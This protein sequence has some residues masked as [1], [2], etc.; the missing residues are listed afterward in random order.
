MRSPVF[1]ATTAAA[2]LLLIISGVVL[3]LHGGGAN[4][5]FA[6]VVKEFLK[7]EN[8]RYKITNSTDGKISVKLDC[9]S[10][11][12]RGREELRDKD[13]KLQNVMIT[14]LKAGKL[15]TLWMTPEKNVANLS[16]V[17]NFPEDEPMVNRVRSLLLKAKD[18]RANDLSSLGE[19]TIDGHRAVGYRLKTFFG[20]KENGCNIE[21][22]IWADAE[23]LLPIRIES[24]YKA[25]HEEQQKTPGEP[26]KT[27]EDPISKS[28]MSDFE[29]N[30]KMDESLFSLEPPAG[31]R[32]KKSKP[33]T[34][35]KAEPTKAES[36]GSEPLS[37]GVILPMDEPDDDDKEAPKEEKSEAKQPKPVNSG[38]LVPV[39]PDWNN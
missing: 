7:V 10:V 33:I 14:E 19:K 35:P 23:T 38:R 21:E 25:F 34:L 8:C 1:R 36:K 26:K 5:S 17:D 24:T 4:V 20:T 27:V 30:V 39:G 16:V 3:W 11:S 2:V 28:I 12:D 29:Y 32:L 22:D 13:G 15:T 18:Q 31:Y 6:D 9:M 37:S